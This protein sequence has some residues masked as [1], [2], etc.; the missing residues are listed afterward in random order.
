MDITVSEITAAQ[1]HE[2]RWP[3][4][5]NGLPKN[6]CEFKGDDLSSTIHLGAFHEGQLVG[7]LTLIEKEKSVIKT[8]FP[9]AKAMFQLRGMGILED[10]QSHGVGVKL[11]R[12]AQS[13]LRENQ[14]D[15]IWFHARMSAVG[16]Y[17]K[18]GYQVIGEEIQL[19]PAGP[20]FKMAKEL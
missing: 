10:Y 12:A 15:V 2:V 6:S 19:E 7:V 20:H 5:R 8:V 11:M 4:L 1:T 17:K 18:M 16:F 14:V 3:V 13:H 9:H